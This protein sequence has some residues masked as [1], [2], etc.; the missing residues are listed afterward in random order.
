VRNTVRV[1]LL[2]KGDSHLG[3]LEAHWGGKGVD[4]V[5]LLL[6]DVV[7]LAGFIRL[8]A[9]KDH[10]AMVSLRK[11]SVIFWG[12]IHRLAS[13]GGRLLGLA[14][15]AEGAMDVASNCGT[16]FEEVFAY[17]SCNGQGASSTF[18]KCS[19]CA[20]RLQG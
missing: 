5:H 10:E 7:L 13:L 2:V 1:V 15:L 8:G 19:G 9:P 18:L 6:S 14:L 11:L 20:P 3:T 4:N 17:P 12:S 16:V